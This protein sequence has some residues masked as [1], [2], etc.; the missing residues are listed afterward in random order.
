MPCVQGWHYSLPQN[1]ARDVHRVLARFGL[2]NEEEVVITS[3]GPNSLP[4]GKAVKLWEILTGYVELA[5]PETTH[6][7]EILAQAASTAAMKSHIKKLKASH[8][9]AVAAR[10]LSVLQILEAHPDINISLGS[11]L[12][13]LPAMRVRQYSI[14]SSP[15]WNPSNVTIT[16]SVITSPPMSGTSTEPFMGVGSNY[17]ASLRPGDRVQMAVRTSARR[18]AH[19][20]CHF[21]R[22]RR[23]RADAWVHSGARGTESHRPRSWKDAALLWVPL[24]RAR[25]PVLRHS[26]RGVDQSWRR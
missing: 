3:V 16:V 17:L 26:P 8:A 25:L 20:R 4:V 22:R 12:Q 7:L 6:D 14:S 5:Q 21:L 19:S 18:P 11:F 13:M 24:A 9:D 1:P 15:L 2:S 10:R 23:H